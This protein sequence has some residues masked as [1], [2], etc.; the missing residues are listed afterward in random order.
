MFI[1]FDLDIFFTTQLWKLVVVLDDNK[2]LTELLTAL[3]LGSPVSDVVAVSY[4]SFC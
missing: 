4:L 1:N 2:S 3:N